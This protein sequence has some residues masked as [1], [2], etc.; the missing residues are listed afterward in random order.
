M[1]SHP[2]WSR[3]AA[4]LQSVCYA[5]FYF[6]VLWCVLGLLITFIPGGEQSWFL[7]AAGLAGFG[8]FIPRW[9]FR[10]AALL[11]VGFTLFAAFD[12]HKRGIEYRDMMERRR[13]ERQMN[14]LG[15]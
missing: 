14:T 1:T 9:P 7:T 15:P 5:L 13:A 2:L 12:G 8:L 6:S 3:L 11:L 10:L 4:S